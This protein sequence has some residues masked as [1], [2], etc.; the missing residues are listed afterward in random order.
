MTE[1]D[2]SYANGLHGR[3]L[4]W[5]LFQEERP[6]LTLADWD[7]R[8]HALT[9]ELDKAHGRNGLDAW[10]RWGR[11][12]DFDRHPPSAVVRWLLDGGFKGVYAS[13]A[14]FC[15]AHFGPSLAAHLGKW[16]GAANLGF[17]G[18]GELKPTAISGLYDWEEWAGKA[19]N[20]RG[21]SFLSLDTLEVVFVYDVSAAASGTV[22][23]VDVPAKYIE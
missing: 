3:Q 23:E 13:D 10:R 8:P 5:A 19:M 6:E 12:A 20:R 22:A 17:P 14:H 1:Y 15:A 9:I 11:F 4:S 18:F 7:D 2:R 21:A 16:K